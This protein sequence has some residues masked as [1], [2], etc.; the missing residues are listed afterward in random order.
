[1]TRAMIAVVLAMAFVAPRGECGIQVG[2]MGAGGRVGFCAVGTDDIG[3]ALGFG[4]HF[5]MEFDVPFGGDIRYTPSLEM[6]FASNDFLDRRWVE[7]ALN[8]VEGRYMIPVPGPT[9]LRPYAGAGIAF[10]IFISSY[11][12]PPTPD[13]ETGEPTRTDKSDASFRVGF[14]MTGGIEFDVSPKLAP[15]AEVKVKAGNPTVFKLQGGL[16]VMF[17][18][19]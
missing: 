7:I 6:W 8:I 4:G 16:T 2:G 12:T 1:M 14:N 18:G 15:F 19:S 17:G 3:P 11:T 10:L 9:I 13:P 5:D